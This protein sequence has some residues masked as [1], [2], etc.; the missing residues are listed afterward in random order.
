M[1]N[2]CAWRLCVSISHRRNAPR[3]RAAMRAQ[4]ARA[5]VN[6][7]PSSNTRSAL[8]T[9]TGGPHVLLLAAAWSRRRSR[10]WSSATGKLT[11]Q[12]LAWLGAG[13]QLQLRVA[14]R[15][16]R[17][18]VVAHPAVAAAAPRDA[19][20]GPAQRQRCRRRNARAAPGAGAARRGARRSRRPRPCLAAAPSPPSL[21]L[22]Q[23]EAAAAR[24]SMTLR[25]RN[26]RA[27]RRGRERQTR[28][29]A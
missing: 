4:R 5:A 9:A 24:V 10:G 12:P 27:Q 2:R 15:E 17:A 14:L 19:R 23:Q 3:N 1:A 7:A 20:V 28:P 25:Y 21:R 6:A 16:V 18:Q 29:R 13:K 22:S 11:E 26:E 8:S